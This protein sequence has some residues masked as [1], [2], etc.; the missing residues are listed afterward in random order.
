MRT[1]QENT[2]QSI[3]IQPKP[4]AASAAPMRIIIVM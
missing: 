1:V 3:A 2:A 4:Q